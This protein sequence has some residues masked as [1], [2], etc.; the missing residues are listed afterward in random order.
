MEV[1]EL[2]HIIFSIDLWK[3]ILS[4]IGIHNYEYWTVDAHIVF[5]CNQHKRMNTNLQFINRRCRWSGKEQ[6]KMGG[7]MLMS[8]N[9]NQTW[10]NGNIE[11][12]SFINHY[13]YN[14]KECENN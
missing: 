3:R 13:A 1:K 2:L 14:C 11:D 6:H 8:R 10:Q 5:K 4:F 9:L 7:V 12:S